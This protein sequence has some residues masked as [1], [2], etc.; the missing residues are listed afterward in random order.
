MYFRRFRNSVT[1]T[2]Q[3]PMNWFKSQAKKKERK[4]KKGLCPISISQNSY[5][6]TLNIEVETYSVLLLKDKTCFLPLSNSLNLVRMLQYRCWKL[7]ALNFSSELSSVLGL[8]LIFL[9]ALGRQ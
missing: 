2:V 5:S 1:N 3:R 9:S 4:K 7:D 8:L 6:A